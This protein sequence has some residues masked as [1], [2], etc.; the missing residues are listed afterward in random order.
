MEDIVSSWLRDL[1][2]YPAPTSWSR[3]ILLLSDHGSIAD[4]HLVLRLRWEVRNDILHPFSPPANRPQQASIFLAPPKWHGTLYGLHSL[5]SF[6]FLWIHQER[7][8]GALPPTTA[9][10]H[11]RAFKT[12]P[13][14]K[15]ERNEER[16]IAAYRTEG[17]Y[18][19]FKLPRT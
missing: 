18:N 13:S 3:K 5:Q 7:T 15:S 12:L 8:R 11:H 1:P 10:S 6:H 4:T 16:L 17:I 2:P 9:C 14:R 19:F